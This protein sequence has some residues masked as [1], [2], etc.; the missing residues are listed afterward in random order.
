MSW[1][2]SDAVAD[3]ATIC[4]VC[5]RVDRNPVGAS[6]D[7]P[8]TSSQGAH[9]YRVTDGWI[10]VIGAREIECKGARRWILDDRQGL[11]INGNR[12]EERRV[13]W[14]SRDAVADD[15]TISVVCRRVDR[16]PVGSIGDTP[17]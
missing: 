4:V 2:G 14:V 10:A 3:H 7:S 15:A 8:Y 13:G 12:S 5:R 16:D 11:T 9:A 1:I 6:G 17:E